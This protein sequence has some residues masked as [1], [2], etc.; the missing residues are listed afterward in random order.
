MSRT[1]LNTFWKVSVYPPLI[2][3]MEKKIHRRMMK[4]WYGTKKYLHFSCSEV[5][6]ANSAV[7]LKD[8]LKKRE[9]T[10][11]LKLFSAPT[12]NLVTY[13]TWVLITPL[14]STFFFFFF[15]F[16]FRHSTL[17]STERLYKILEIGILPQ[18]FKGRLFIISPL[19]TGMEQITQF[20]E[21]SNNHCGATLL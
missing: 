3:V 10:T 21:Q 11:V 15:F 16:W 4:H 9:L 14:L 6:L 18:N 17:L 1:S 8:W 12:A 20:I 19:N 7:E 2:A 13:P 5:S